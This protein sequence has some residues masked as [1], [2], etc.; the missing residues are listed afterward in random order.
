MDAQTQRVQVRSAPLRPLHR[1]CV[2]Q[3]GAA[4]AAHNGAVA[5]MLAAGGTLVGKTHMDELAFSVSGENF[6]HGT[7]DNPIAPGRTVGGSSSGSAAAVA[8]GLADVAL[9]TDTTGSV[10]VR[11]TTRARGAH[12]PPHAFRA[13][14]PVHPRRPRC[15]V[16]CVCVLPPR[17]CACP[18]PTAGCTAS[19]P[20]TAS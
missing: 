13:P 12:V 20:P 7:C 3:V 6:H 14:C 4:P 11:A 18:P 16:L 5:G 2:L 9:G 17:R 15:T 1:V 10:R 19:A 8:A